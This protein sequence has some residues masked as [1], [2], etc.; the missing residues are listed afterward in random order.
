M[1][2]K[3]RRQPKRQAEPFLQRRVVNGRVR[4][5]VRW[6]ED[7]GQGP[8]EMSKSFIDSDEAG[9]F[10]KEC[11]LKLGIVELAKSFMDEKLLPAGDLTKVTEEYVND[12]QA[13]QKQ[14]SQYADHLHGYLKDLPTL[15]GWK[16]TSDI[17]ADAC[18][19]IA[20]RLNSRGS[21]TVRQTQISLKSMVR[22]MKDRYA[23]ADGILLGKLRKH[24]KKKYY[25]WTDEEK[26][27]ILAE[28]TKPL[29]YSE[30]TTTGSLRQR[31][32]ARRREFHYAARCHALFP[33]VWLQMLWGVRPLESSL[34]TVGDWDTRK[35]ELC[36]P[37]V[38]TKSNEERRFTVDQVTG[39][40]LDVLTKDRG[41]K[42]ILFRS[43]LGKP[44]QPRLMS[45]HFRCVLKNLRLRGSLYSSRHYAVTTLLE[46]MPSQL[47]SVM[48][49]TGHASLET[50]NPYVGLK[51]Q[52]Q[53]V[54]GPA[55][56]QLYEAILKRA[57]Q[58]VMPVPLAPT[59][60]EPPPEHAMPPPTTPPARRPPDEDPEAVTVDFVVEAS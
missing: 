45:R 9:R 14:T 46:V 4:H 50:I 26:D 25:I 52:R 21:Y 37:A 57:A 7:R 16:V 10:L 29:R 19:R 42:E 43:S 6:P 54:A 17:P 23:F 20:T 11:R 22:V 39:I 44:W 40:I 5:L 28:L 15:F 55:Y 2:K 35:R 41:L 12:V 13:V 8:V 48:A 18:A 51:G 34:L 3:S 60:A 30:A 33:V 49:I 53:H 1:R 31:D 32:S 38:I 47:A 58:P 59:A 36:L 56:D 27:L 24:K